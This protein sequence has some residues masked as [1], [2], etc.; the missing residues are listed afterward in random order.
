M[1]YKYIL[2]KA[3]RAAKRAAL[4][5]VGDLRSSAPFLIIFMV[6]PAAI[7]SGVYKMT[8]SWMLTVF[9]Y[10][11]WIIMFVLWRL[12]LIRELF[13]SQ[14]RFIEVSVWGKTLD[15]GNWKKGEWVRTKP[16]GWKKDAA[17]KEIRADIP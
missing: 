15:K 12:Y 3:A 7:L 1:Q 14:I 8:G 5:I 13:M 11:L 2:P 9:A 6:V 4:S 10:V 17:A 16:F